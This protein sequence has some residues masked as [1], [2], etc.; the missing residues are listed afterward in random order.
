MSDPLIE[1]DPDENLIPNTADMSNYFS[2]NDFNTYTDKF[3]TDEIFLL[4]Q[5]IRSFSANRNYFDTFLSSLTVEPSFIV[6]T[7]TWNKPEFSNSYSLDNYFANHSYRSRS[8]GRGGGV[9][10]YVKRCYKYVKLEELSSCGDNIETCVVRVDLLGGTVCII[11]VYRPHLGTNE[12]FISALDSILESQIVKNSKLVIIA[13]DMNINLLDENCPETQNYLSYLQSKHFLPG[14]LKPTRFSSVDH[15]LPTCLDHIW[16]NNL[17][18]FSSGIISQ[19]ITDHLPNF[20]SFKSPSPPD[21][22]NTIKISFRPYSRIGEDKL[23]EKFDSINWNTILSGTDVNQK[24]LNFNSTINECYCKSFPIK[25]KIITEKRYNKPWLTSFLIQQIKLKSE[26]FKSYRA[27]LISVSTHNRFRNKVNK[28]VKETRDNYYLSVFTSCRN[29][30]RKSWKALNEL[31]GRSTVKTEV[32]EL[33]HNG[34]T[35][36][37]DYSIAQ[38]FN[39]FFASIGTDLDSSLPPPTHFSEPPTVPRNSASFFLAPV[40][41]PEC[42]KTIKSLKLTK[43]DINQIPV[44]IFKSSLHKILEPLVQ[45][46]NDSF[47][48]G[49]FPDQLKIARVTPIF[50]NGITTNP[51]NYRPI[52]SLPFISKIFETLFK[53]RLLSFLRKFSII[54]SSQ[55]GFLKGKNTSHALLDLTEFIYKNLDEKNHILS[56]FV[57]LRKAFDTVNHRILLDKLERCGVRGVGLEWCRNYLT[58]R[59]Q[60]VSHGGSKS[61]LRHMSIGVPQGSVLG[62]IFFLIYI[63]DLATSSDDLRYILFADDTTLILS[64]K[65]FSS[66]TERTNSELNNISQWAVKNRLTINTDKTDSMIFSNR[67]YP[68]NEDLV[69]LGPSNIH[70]KQSCKFL[71]VYIDDRISFSSHINQITNKLSKSAGILYRIRD[72]LT[73]QARLSFY[74][75]FVYPYLSYNIIIWGKTHSYLLDSLFVMQKRIV[76]NIAAA[77][78]LAHTT[79]LFREFSILKIPDIFKYAV[80]CHMFKLKNTFDAPHTANTRFRDLPRTTYHRLTMTQRAVSFTGPSEWNLLPD[81]IRNIRKFNCFKKALKSYLLSGYCDNGP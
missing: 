76:R 52:S 48:S 50:K 58:N 6:L 38:T 59:K 29:N 46:I 67:P 53:T 60:Y 78:F 72:C 73:P 61:E 68:P 35:V 11:G 15:I 40:T 5:N 70:P 54:T 75:S 34:E 49:V 24:F 13:G 18:P 2:V 28:L 12:N 80:C 47:A 56:V 10:L 8:G 20:I 63:N 7:E 57:D 36:V 30:M 79:P 32:K 16:I 27:G 81:H 22:K 44:N 23:M 69:K 42:E 62:P 55:Y 71:G 65:N 64:D 74:Y 39:N 66:L 51:S 1:L 25:T 77:P 43:N 4:N 33:V 37:G 9:S 3:K 19:D 17:I 31:C 21:V 41:H 45:I 14:I 26:Y